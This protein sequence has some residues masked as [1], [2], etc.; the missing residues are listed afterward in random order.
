MV[1]LNKVKDLI[2]F[3]RFFVH[4][5]FSEGQEGEKQKDIFLRLTT[6]NCDM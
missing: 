2:M 5:V 4:S 6:G 3:N 1:I